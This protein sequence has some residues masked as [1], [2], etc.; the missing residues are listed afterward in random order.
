MLRETWSVLL[1][2]RN[3]RG[4]QLQHCEDIERYPYV[5]T[6][7]TGVPDFSACAIGRAL[8]GAVGTVTNSVE[9]GCAVTVLILYQLSPCVY[10]QGRQ[11]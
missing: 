10:T 5:L 2:H 4:L 7:M 9:I 3:T 11:R 1:I 6:S 8:E